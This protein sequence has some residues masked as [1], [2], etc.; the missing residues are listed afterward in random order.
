VNS[1]RT[2]RGTHQPKQPQTATKLAHQKT[3]T[4]CRGA[5]RGV[6]IVSV[7]VNRHTQLNSAARHSRRSPGSGRSTAP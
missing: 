5:S 1:Q 2:M 6:S 4:R 7:Q 3:A